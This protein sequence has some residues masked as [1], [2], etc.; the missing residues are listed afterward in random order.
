ML[1]EE[2]EFI[3]FEQT[4]FRKDDTSKLESVIAQLEIDMVMTEPSS[5][6]M[7]PSLNYPGDPPWPATFEIHEIRLS[8]GVDDMGPVE[9]SYSLTLTES[10]FIYFFE[11]G[12]DAIQRAH[13]WASENEDS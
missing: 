9:S 10:Q 8:I 1:Y 7:P 3:L 4:H 5:P 6:G 13:D 12:M 2:K 11:N